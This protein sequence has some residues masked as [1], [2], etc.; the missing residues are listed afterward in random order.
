MKSLPLGLLL[1]QARAACSWLKNSI[2]CAVARMRSRN[3]D[4]SRYFASRAELCSALG[5]VE[6]CHEG[7]FQ[8][9][10]HG[11]RG[12]RSRR[13]VLLLVV[14]SMLVLFALIG[15]TFVLVASQSR[16]A[17]RGEA[18]QDQQTDTPSRQLDDVFAQIVRDTT[19]ARSAIQNHSL[20]ADLY[21][22]A[23][24]KGSLSGPAT[25]VAGTGGQFIDVPVATLATSSGYLSG[26]APVFTPN[27]FPSAAQLATPG[28]FNG[29]VLTFTSGSVLNKSTRVLGYSPGVS[30]RIL[31]QEGISVASLTGTESFLIN[32]RP[33][34]G[35]GFGFNRATGHLNLNYLNATGPNAY[36]FAFLGR[37]NYTMHGYGSDGLQNTADDLPPILI[38]PNE[39]YDAADAQNWALAYVPL[40][41]IAYVPDAGGNASHIPSPLAGGNLNNSKRLVLPSY[42][43]PD[44]V[45]FWNNKLTVTDHED[46]PLDLRRQIMLRPQGK[47]RVTTKQT[48]HPNFTGSNPS[49]HPILGPWDVDSDGDGIADSVWIDIGLPAQTAPDGRR[50]KPL[51]AILITDLDGRLNV[52]A[53]GSIAHTQTLAYSGPFA[54]NLAPTSPL[55]SPGHGFGTAD[56]S[57][58]GLFPSNTEYAA[59]MQGNSALSIAGRYGAAVGTAMP[60]FDATN[61][62][63]SYL[64]QFEHPRT[65][66]LFTSFMTPPDLWARGVLGLDHRG[67]PLRYGVG[68]GTYP[69]DATD[70]PYELDLSHKA[71]RGIG[72]TNGRDTPFSTAELERVL[73]RYDYD[74]VVLPSRLATLLNPA[75]AIAHNRLVTTDSY[76]L[77]VPAFRPTRDMLLGP[78]KAFDTG[79]AG[80]DGIGA[81]LGTPATNLTIM[82]LVRYR[83]IKAGVSNVATINSVSAQLISPELI[84]GLRLDL[85]RPLGNGRDDNTNGV[86]DEVEEALIVAGEPLWPA[87]EGTAPNGFANKVFWHNP[88]EIDWNG[89]STVDQADNAF[90]RQLLARHLYVL[91]M[92]L[93][94]EAAVVG[95]KEETARAIAQWAINV[96]DFRDADSVMTPFEFP[97]DP[98]TSTGWFVDNKLGGTSPDDSDTNRGLVWGCERPE[99]LIT[100]TFAFHDRRTEDTSDEPSGATVGNGV[101]IETDFDQKLVPRSGLF[102]ELYNPWTAV[103]NLPGEFY[104]DSAAATPWSAGVRLDKL[105]PA[106]A[107]SQ[108]PVWRV[109]VVTG[110]NKQNDLNDPV[111]A[112]RPTN[113]D[114][115]RSIYFTNAA[116][117]TITTDTNQYYTNLGTL[118]I[119][120]GSYAV[121]GPAEAPTSQTGNVHHIVIGRKTSGDTNANAYSLT[122]PPTRRI[123]LDP[124][125]TTA[126]VITYDNTATEEPASGSSKPAVAIVINRPADRT[127]SVSEPTAGYGATGT[128]GK[129]QV[130]SPVLDVPVDTATELKTTGT[131]LAYKTLHLQRL[132]NP[133]AP[134]NIDSNPYI[135]I[136]TM[137]VDLTAFNGVTNANDPDDPNDGSG[138]DSVMFATR[139]RGEQNDSAAAANLWLREP[140][141]K[142]D[143]ASPALPTGTNF[144]ARQLQHTLGFLNTPLG[145]A[146]PGGS[147]PAGYLGD[148]QNVPFPWLTWNNRPFANPGELMQVPR[149]RPSRLTADYSKVADAVGSTK[150]PFTDILGPY[151]HLA[152]FYHSNVTSGQSLHLYRV[153]DYVQV[154]SP[155]VGTETTLSGNTFA[156]TP[157]AYPI[158]PTTA[159]AGLRAPFN[160]VFNYREPG[161]VNI[162]TI[163]GDFGGALN[164]IWSGILNQPNPATALAWNYVDAS[165]R[166]PNGSPVAFAIP[167]RGG[168]T[169]DQLPGIGPYTDVDTTLF[170]S[171]RPAAL[172]MPL[173]K[174]TTTATKYNDSDRNP[175]FRYQVQQKMTGLLTTRSNVYAIWI[176]VGNFEVSPW[177]SGVDAAHPDGLQLGAELGSDSGNVK[178]HRAFYIFDRSIPVGFEPGKDHNIENGVLLRRFIE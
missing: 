113:T 98:F 174:Q 90:D 37:P 92:L 94:D 138:E 50:F 52:N 175:Y 18:R 28:F 58:L 2:G 103:E 43:R 24:A 9:A 95:T 151:G 16:R 7:I 20:L 29:C 145:P 84:A 10:V 4:A 51:V 176:T 173:F 80:D 93:K 35:A 100:E 77:P 146:F 128:D 65:G 163:P 79:G 76:D 167:F 44:L 107:G 101:P 99:L 82:D 168:G 26:T 136:D 89:D 14:L 96:V 31:A 162:N 170:R 126:G 122:S 161:R 129:E 21:G 39:D 70:D 22:F 118:P 23:G 61:D 127:L 8:K 143:V 56:I 147:A 34:S 149:S 72:P 1:G 64:K 38:S 13:G 78:D 60:G 49:F 105:T 148:P 74:S 48:D 159:L 155:F 110:A 141:T 131:T 120:P 177:T 88:Y 132:A 11:P 119:L 150:N 123:D 108:S 133:L 25:A 111:V 19:N 63:F 153:F 55:L 83:L 164:P 81:T 6:K 42:H 97:I 152:N 62:P 157:L 27:P 160:R 144:F 12:S 154:P 46:L 57:L 67:Q 75:S 137:P 115:E 87:S 114:V 68:P 36:P 106:A 156:V 17:M 112:N 102:V 45:E 53:H 54:G 117:T 135:T 47:L 130:F 5:E 33:F 32:G 178:R 3:S 139:Q 166:G 109:V 66:T 158:T 104:Y 91:A 71:L 15:I 41:P 40:T 59:L 121:I 116:P 73:R 124:T 169:V 69:T 86:I 30:I 165:R 134:W 172:D 142:P 125:S 85:N 171:S 140:F